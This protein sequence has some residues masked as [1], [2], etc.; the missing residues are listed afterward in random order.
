MT[1]KKLSRFYKFYVETIA[2]L[3]KIAEKKRMTK[4]AVLTLL[5]DEEYDKI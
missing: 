5:I 4:T 2:K 3:E 1:K